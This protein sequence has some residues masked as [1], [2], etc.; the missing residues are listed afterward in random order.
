[1]IEGT[2]EYTDCADVLLYLWMINV[3]TD[4]EYNKIMSKLNRA[5]KVKEQDH[6]HND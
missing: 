2:I 4:G 3:I 1:M 6:E 5:Y